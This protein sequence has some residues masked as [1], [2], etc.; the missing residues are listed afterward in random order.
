MYKK[1]EDQKVT[2][3]YIRNFVQVLTIATIG[4]KKYQWKVYLTIVEQPL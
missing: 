1:Q 2:I 3:T 4:V